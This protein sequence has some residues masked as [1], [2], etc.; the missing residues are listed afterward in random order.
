MGVP[1]VVEDNDAAGRRVWRRVVASSVKSISNVAVSDEENNLAARGGLIKILLSLQTDARASGVAL[2]LAA[3]VVVVT[4]ILII[5]IRKIL[6]PV[7]FN[8]EIFGEIH[9]DEIHNAASMRMMIG[10]GFGGIGL[11][12]LMLGFMLEAG[13]ATT[14]LLYALA[15]AYAFMLATLL[16]ANKKGHLHEIPKPPLVIFPVMLILCVAGAIL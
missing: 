5:A 11:M 15:A 13:D 8:E 14:S 10:A 6:A 9:P 3:H 16:F 12:G 2:R 4:I 1:K 7:K